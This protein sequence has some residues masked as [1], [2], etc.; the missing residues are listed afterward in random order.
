[1][2]WASQFGGIVSAEVKTNPQTGESRG[3]GFITFQDPAVAQQV[4]ANNA[5]NVMEGK[6]IDCKAFGQVD[7]KGGKGAGLNDPN[8]PRLFIGGLPKTA[9]EEALQAH[10]SQ[11]SGGEI[12]EFYLKKG[13]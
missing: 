7:Q 3:F 4:V 13:P 2:M 11:M 6:K 10:L 8:N 9:T 1:M 5:N 12:T